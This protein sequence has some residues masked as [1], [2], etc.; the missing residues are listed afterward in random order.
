MGD[1]GR[2]EPAGYP[3]LYTKIVDYAVSSQVRGF[4]IA[5]AIIFTLMLVWLRSLRLALIS[6]VPNAFPVLVMMGVMGALG[7]DLDIATATV[8]AIVIGV[9]IDD[10]VHFLLHWRE[11]ERAGK[12]WDESVDYCFRHA[13]LPAVITTLLLVVGYP[14]LMLADVGSVVSFGLL[15]TVAAAAALFADLVVLPLLLRLVPG[16]IDR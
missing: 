12:S 11:A 2:I 6:L 8:A 3:P 10:T 13:G 15:T 4:F 5:L 16:R 9:S 7:I 1:L 14:V